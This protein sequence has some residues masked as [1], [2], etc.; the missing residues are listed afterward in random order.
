MRGIEA[1]PRAGPKVREP[2]KE[3]PDPLN[4]PAA[5]PT[6]QIDDEKVKV[7]E[8]RLGYIHINII[9]LHY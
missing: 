5:I 2:M 3:V 7:T 8:W 6:V 4:R 1:P 9:S